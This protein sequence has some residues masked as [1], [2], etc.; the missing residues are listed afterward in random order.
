M[1]TSGDKV[2]LEWRTWFADIQDQHL[3]QLQREGAYLIQ[4]RED[5]EWVRVSPDGSEMLLGYRDAD[6]THV[7][8]DSKKER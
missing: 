3:F 7:S 5:G 4:R 2:E 8:E 1:E 6:G